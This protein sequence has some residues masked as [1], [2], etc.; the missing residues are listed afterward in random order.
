MK[1]LRFIPGPEQVDKDIKL[2]LDNGFHA[3]LVD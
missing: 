1:I 2:K 3:V